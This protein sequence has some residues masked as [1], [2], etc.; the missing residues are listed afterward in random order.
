ML[1]F[2]AGRRVIGV[3]GHRRFVH[4]TVVDILQPVVEEPQLLRLD[5][6]IIL[7][8]Y[9]APGTV[10]VRADDQFA[11]VGKRIAEHLDGG[12]LGLGFF[13]V[14]AAVYGDARSPDFVVVGVQTGPRPP[15][16][17]HRMPAVSIGDTQVIHKE[18]VK[19]QVFVFGLCLG[20]QGRRVGAVDW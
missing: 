12:Q 5:R 18:R 9:G 11:T 8:G 6:Q 16:S 3:I 7:G 20:Q 17:E 13:P 2:P 1:P 4:D 10:T 15:V 19:L 14:G